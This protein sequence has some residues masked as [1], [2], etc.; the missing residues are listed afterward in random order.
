MTLIGFTAGWT[1]WWSVVASIIGITLLLLLVIAARSMHA[2]RVNARSKVN[3]DQAIDLMKRAWHDNDMEVFER[4]ERKKHMGTGFLVEDPTSFQRSSD[5]MYDLQ[6]AE[7]RH[8]YNRIQIDNENWWV[9]SVLTGS[10]AL[11]LTIIMICTMVPF[12]KK[13]WSWYTIS[14][15]ITNITSIQL[16]SDS[17]TTLTGE[18]IV[19]LDTMRGLPLV[20]DDQRI[21]SYE[22]QQVTL[23]CSPDWQNWGQ[24]ADKWTCDLS[25]APG[26]DIEP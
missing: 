23:L 6:R 9:A 15:G 3:S 12:D 18:Y 21:R 16:D 10:V 11:L 14:G 17:E 13:Y 1:I 25:E 2:R 24:S 22:G 8:G 26:L 4:S 20:M 7:E 5:R 19:E